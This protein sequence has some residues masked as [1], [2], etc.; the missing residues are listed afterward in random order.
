MKRKPSEKELRLRKELAERTIKLNPHWNEL[1]E[2]K[3][4]VMNSV[5]FEHH[6]DAP[7]ENLD[8]IV[9][10]EPK[11]LGPIVKDI[12][13]LI[14]DEK[15]EEAMEEL[16]KRMTE[17]PDEP[18]LYS[19]KMV[20]EML[21]RPIN[22]SARVKNVGCEALEVALK[23][24]APSHV[25][26]VL[27]NMGILALSEGLKEYSKI[28]YLAAYFVNKNALSP[29]ENIIGWCSRHNELEEAMIWVD[30]LIKKFPNWT[31]NQDIISF[32]TKDESLH[33][34]REHNEFQDTI[35][36]RIEKLKAQNIERN[37]YR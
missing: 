20:I 36:K 15:L 16:E 33:N 6:E 19:L 27:N 18:R 22:E 29:L 32:F 25:S 3:E 5:K 17:Y 4:D 24:N 28:F 34:L 8:A 11:E 9:E 23:K 26:A 37:N 21:D 14:R 31:A 7:D 13:S 30:R 2:S 35:L 10:T 12:S 1:H